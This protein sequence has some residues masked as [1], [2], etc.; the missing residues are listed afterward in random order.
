[1]F[2]SKLQILGFKSFPQK[3]ELR[4]D[5]GVTSIV[6]PN[7]CG[8]TNLLDAIRWVL[9]EQRTTL[10][11]SS[12]ME[13]VIFNGTKD[14]RPLGMAEVTLVIENS[15]GILPIDYD[16]VMVTRRLFRSG[17]SEYLLNKTPCRLK[18]ITELFL[19]TGVGI[20]AYSVI[21]PEM[22]EAILSEKA[23]ERRFLFEE[24]A[25]ITKYKLRKREA[26]R[27]L[28][29]TENDLLRL[30]D[31][32][33]EVEKQ[34][35]SLRRQK[36]KAERYKKLTRQIR[37]VEIKL[38]Q[39]E[40]RVLKKKE[41]ELDERLKISADQSQETTSE[42]DKEEAQVESVKLMLL[43]IEKQTGGIQRKIGELSEKGFQIEREISI[44]RER[45]ANL[46]KL[47]QRNDQELENLKTRLTSEESQRQEKGQKLSQLALE[48]DA[49]RKECETEE[50]ALLDSDEKLQRMKEKLQKVTGNLQESNEDLSRHGG[51]RSHTETQIEELRHRERLCA[52][53]M[54]TLESKIDEASHRLAELG[55]EDEKRKRACNAEIN[56]KGL[57]K[58][59][60]LTRDINSCGGKKDRK[61]QDKGYGL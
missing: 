26:E 8:K 47:I 14:L 24:A 46:E 50:T 18:D 17:E 33:S 28:E 45:K 19:D 56:E 34:V 40:F 2:L 11:R 39:R 38:S 44:N 27:K 23:E 22:V 48:I 52:E 12:K 29:Q 37:E 3:T 6:G 42:L 51:E 20:H 61:G 16:Q 4:F 53:E 58:D 30:G 32:L 55:L 25:G 36:G 10:L 59:R 13:D 35:N 49:K 41:A 21:Q 54:R 1:M 9:G 5:R 15:R 31:I 60:D 57:K 43:E 7:G